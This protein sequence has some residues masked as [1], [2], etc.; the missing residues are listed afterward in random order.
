MKMGLVGL[1]VLAGTAHASVSIKDF[2]VIRQGG[3]QIEVVVHKDGKHILAFTRGCNF[4]KLSAKEQNQTQFTL[5]GDVAT[6]AAAI[7]DNKATL[8]AHTAITEPGIA[9]GTWGS[10]EVNFT[11]VAHDRSVKSDKK[12]IAAPL[13]LIGTKISNVLHGIETEAREANKAV[14]K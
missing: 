9:T 4:K 13:V 14:C 1:M 2:A 12:T 10:M 7:L 3:G 6:D 11:Y 5:K 8:A